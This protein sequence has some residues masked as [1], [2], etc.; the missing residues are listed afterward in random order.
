MNSIMTIKHDADKTYN[1]TK[2]VV[3]STSGEPGDVTNF[4]EYILGNVKLYGIRNYHDLTVD[5]CAKYTR[6]EL[7][8]SLRSRDAYQVNLLVGGFNANTQK[9]ALYCIDYLASIA[10]IPF[11]AHGYCSYFSY[12]VLDRIYHPNMTVEEAL[13]ALAACI[14]ELNTRFII[15]HTSYTIKIIDASG[16][17]DVSSDDFLKRL[18]VQ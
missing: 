14:S 11:A 15:K 17:S 8:M 13:N 1:L 12:S 3:M 7:A 16:I 2:N 10:N 6:R 18:T 4:C 9:P 5:A